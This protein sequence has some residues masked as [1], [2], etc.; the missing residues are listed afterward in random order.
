M[1]GQTS[2][3]VIKLTILR[4]LNGLWYNFSWWYFSLK[5]TKHKKLVTHLNWCKGRQYFSRWWSCFGFYVCPCYSR[6]RH[7]LTLEKLG[8]QNIAACENQG[9]QCKL[10]DHWKSVKRFLKKIITWGDAKKKTKRLTEIQ[11]LT[12]RLHPTK[13]HVSL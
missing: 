10:S 8:A 4:K 11:V 5:H 13:S 6:R 9:K 7:Y 1:I 2:T 3:W 12:K